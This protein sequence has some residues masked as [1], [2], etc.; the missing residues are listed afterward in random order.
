VLAAGGHRRVLPEAPARFPLRRS[1]HFA[2]PFGQSH[3]TSTSSSL[4]RGMSR[5]IPVAA[6]RTRAIVPPAAASG[7]RA[8]VAPR[9][10]SGEG[11][12]DHRH[13]VAEPL[14]HDVRRRPSISC[15]P[16]PPLGPSYRM[17]TSRPPSPASEDPSHASSC[18]SKI[19]ADPRRPHLRST[20]AVLT[21]AP[22]VASCRKGPRALFRAVRVG[23]GRMTAGSFV[24]A[25]HVLLQGLPVT[26]RQPRFMRPGTLN[27]PKGRRDPPGAVHVLHVVLRRRRHLAQRGRSSREI[28]SIAPGRTGPRLVRPASVWRSCS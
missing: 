10:P 11:R 6:S 21:T 24:A 1:C 27:T 16:G 3:P 4:R 28:A 2:P 8:V 5:R 26:V 13:L 22:S 14:A 12:G 17:T 25:P 7:R 15:I 23:Q 19:T 18:D 9:G 20:P